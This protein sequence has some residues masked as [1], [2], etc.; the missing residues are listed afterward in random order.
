[1]KKLTGQIHVLLGVFRHPFI[2]FLFV[3]Y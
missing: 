2:S 1:L 3:L